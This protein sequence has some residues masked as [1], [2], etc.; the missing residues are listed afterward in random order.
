MKK[1]KIHFIIGMAICAATLLLFLAF[2]ERLPDVVAM[3][4][5]ID[6]SAGNSVPKQVLVFGLPVLFTAINLYKGLSLLRED[7]TSVIKFYIVPCIAI[8]VST[9]ALL[10]GL[11]IGGAL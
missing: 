8:A 7:E 5:T 3:Q 9:F 11:N 4:I 2:W 1:S 10:V 6:G